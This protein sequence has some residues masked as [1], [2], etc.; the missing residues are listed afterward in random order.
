M[1]YYV[2][3]L[4]SKKHGTLYRGVTNDIVRRVY[5]HKSKAAPGFTSRYDVGKLIWFEVYD[6]AVTAITRE[7]ELK[8]W[9]RDWKIRLIEEQNP[10]WDDLY[11]GIA[12]RRGNP[13]DARG[14]GF[15]AHRFAMPRNDE[16]KERAFYPPCHSG[17]RV[18]RA[19]NP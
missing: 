19:R 9:R 11:P 18:A 15:R 16:W 14:Y 8:K 1:A 12:A 13:I 10:S 2:Y 6:D 17:A 5:E 4:A 7:K 3:L